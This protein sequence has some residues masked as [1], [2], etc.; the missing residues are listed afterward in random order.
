MNPKDTSSEIPYGYCQCGC[1]EQTKLI[2]FNRTHCGWVKGEPFRFIHGHT[3]KKAP[4]EIRELPDGCVAIVLSRGY[5]VVVDR[6][7]FDLVR[8]LRWFPSVRKNQ[9]YAMTNP[10]I[11]M[12]RFISGNPKN[13]MIDHE[14]GN[15]LNNRRSNLRRCTRSQ[16][17][18]NSGSRDGSASIYKG[19]S[20]LGRTGTW[21]AEITIHGQCI[22]LLISKDQEEAARA[23][24]EAARSLY[25][26]FAWLNF[27]G[28]I[29]T[30]DTLPANV[31]AMKEIA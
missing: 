18:A 23:Y 25:G 30:G 31:S 24:D 16:N 1:G 3:P 29:A 17:A 19:V 8:S 27:P 4:Q 5:E 20:R 28:T 11:M 15:G 6:E 14:D 26:E 9:T 10:G 7:D 12:H 21:R 2:G 22:P 13:F